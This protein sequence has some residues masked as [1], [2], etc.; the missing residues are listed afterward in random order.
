M[1]ASSSS[2]LHTALSNHSAKGSPSPCSHPVDGEPPAWL[3]GAPL[4]PLGGQ[5][6]CADSALRLL[7]AGALALPTSCGFFVCEMGVIIP[8]FSKTTFKIK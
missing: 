3:Q 7:W 8:S 5:G 2:S 4:L 1:K 6:E